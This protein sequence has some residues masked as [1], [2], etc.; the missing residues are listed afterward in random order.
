MKKIF[1]FAALAA[2]V[3]FTAC[4]KEI[5][6]E[7]IEPAENTQEEVQPGYVQM[8]FSAA[9]EADITKA[10]LSGKSVLWTGDESIA[11]FDHDAGGAANKFDIEG[12]GAAA[13]FTGTVPVG[14]THFT[15]VYPYSD[16]ISYAAGA[17]SPIMTV[18]PAVQEATLGSFDP[19]AATFVATATNTDASLKFAPAFALFKVDVDVD[20]VVSVVVSTTTNN[21][22]GS[23]LVSRSGNV[24]DGDGDKSKEI[25]LRKSDG[26]VLAKGNYYIVTRFKKNYE[27]FTLK[28]FTSEA[29]IGSRVSV[30]GITADM[31]QQKDIMNL[32]SLSSFPDAPHCSWYEYYQAGY[33]VTIAGETYNLSTDGAATLLEDEGVFSSTKEGVIFV[34][35]DASVTNTSETTITSDVIITS[36]DPSHPGTYTG[37]LSKSLLLKSGSLVMDN[38]IVELGALTSGQFM[39]KKDNDGNF[40]AL[41]LNHCDIKN[42]K[43]YVF[44]PNSSFLNNGIV[45]IKINGCRIGTAAD[46]QLF[47]VNSNATTL[48]GYK[49]F[50]FTN[51]VLYSNTGNA[52]QTYVFA[53]SAGGIVESTC[54]QEV[55][56]DNNLFYNIAASNGI[57]RTHYLK[58]IYIRNNI[59]WAKDGSYS[60]NIKMFKANL[61]VASASSVFEGASSN[62]YCFGDLGSKSW[63]ISDTACRGPLTNVTVLDS[64]PI[65][66]FDDS[67]GEFVLTSTYQTY[68]PQE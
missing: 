52:Q 59:L 14:T 1:V 16:A 65:S 53:T 2:M 47:A 56:M 23:V 36:D 34:A 63:T 60:S 44:S 8:R 48:A 20:N 32:G 11:V 67:T 28:Y 17:G 45:S 66:S 40:T 51:N 37:T 25:I 18:I 39:T 61:N 50:T 49:D 10:Y 68:G 13:S 46:V 29:L 27:N 26:S 30:A 58:S 54:N 55:V 9:M 57:F 21:L 42:V 38:L 7:I 43:R 6:S 15:A 64:T 22:A 12:S 41:T 5:S 62:N 35:A 31:L 3:A 4:T 24:S 33:D 19:A